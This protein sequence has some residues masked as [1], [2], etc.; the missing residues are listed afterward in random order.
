M[1]TGESFSATAD[2]GFDIDRFKNIGIG[3]DVARPNLFLVNFYLPDALVDGLNTDPSERLSFLCE[4]TAIPG[5][6]MFTQ[7]DV[8]RYGYGP[9]EKRPVAALFNDLP[10]NFIGDGEGYI[11]KFFHYWMNFIINFNSGSQTATMNTVVGPTSP[12]SETGPKP[13]EVRYR[14]D[15]VAKVEIVTYDQ[16]SNRVL[17]TTL[18][19]AWPVIVDNVSLSWAEQDGFMKILT[20]FN[21]RDW[22]STSYAASDFNDMS[23]D[24]LMNPPALIQSLVPTIS[25]RTNSPVGNLVARTL[26]NLI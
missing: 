23:L 24:D 13:Y 16:A 4:E 17:V 3:S 20:T 22:Y 10:L 9:M 1:N 6:A 15:Y 19:Q 12:N 14:D 21:Y 2:N 25:I 26:Q 7:N 11:L 8:Q 18:N 5:V